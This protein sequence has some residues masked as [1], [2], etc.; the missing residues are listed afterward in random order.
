METKLDMKRDPFARKLS[1]PLGE[2]SV[3]RGAHE[4][5]DP[6]DIVTGITRHA[7]GDWGDLD[8]DQ[9]KQ[10]DLSVNRESRLISQYTAKNGS[11]FWVITEADRSATTVL[12]LEEYEA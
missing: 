1:F 10:N 5:L 2:V 3:A 8:E 4:K 12:L 9:W 6:A 7:R 11:W